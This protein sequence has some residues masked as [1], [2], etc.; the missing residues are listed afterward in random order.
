MDGMGSVL[1]HHLYRENFRVTK[2]TETGCGWNAVWVI[3]LGL[4][5][6]HARRFLPSPTC[7]S[8]ISGI[9]AL[10]SVVVFFWSCLLFHAFTVLSR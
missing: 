7:T 5:N 9:P 1:K 3:Y 6:G 10:N 4:G 2:E 8:Q